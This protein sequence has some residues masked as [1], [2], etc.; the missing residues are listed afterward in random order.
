MFE[1]GEI[2]AFFPLIAPIIDSVTPNMAAEK[3]GIK[4]NDR[5]ISLNNQPI[6]HWKQL[7]EKSKKLSNPVAM[8][9]ARNSQLDTLEVTP[10]AEGRIGVYKLYT[11]IE[12]THVDLGI[13]KSIVE[14]FP[15]AIGRYTTTSLS[16]N[17]FLPKK[18]P[19]RWVALELLEICSQA[20]GI[21]ESFVQHSLNFY[22]VGL[23]ECIT[24][25]RTRWGSRDVFGL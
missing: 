20:L 24:H 12:T 10:N 4:A 7:T 1:S 25:S 6:H 23:Y 22:N 19:V 15:T 8:V 13:S 9:V 3:A 17:I 18:V 11:G 21:G 5:I 14:G 2:Q 16:S